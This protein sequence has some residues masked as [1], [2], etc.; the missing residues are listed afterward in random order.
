MDRREYYETHDR[1]ANDSSS[2]KHAYEL[3]HFQAYEPDEAS[4][5]RK[6]NISMQNVIQKHFCLCL[7]THAIQNGMLKCSTHT[8]HRKLYQF[9]QDIGLNMHNTYSTLISSA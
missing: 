5:S 9:L 2:S 8:R 4:L 7:I 3:R 1:G 6:D